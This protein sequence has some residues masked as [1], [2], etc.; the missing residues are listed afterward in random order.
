MI[1]TEKKKSKYR[2]LF[3]YLYRH[4]KLIKPIFG[5]T[6]YIHL[7]KEFGRLDKKYV[8]EKNFNEGVMKLSKELYA[9]IHGLDV[10]ELG[11]YKVINDFRMMPHEVI[12]TSNQNNK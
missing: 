8:T 3:L 10:S 7:S 4:F 11:N 1:G 6:K 9:Y 12:R 2:V 5:D